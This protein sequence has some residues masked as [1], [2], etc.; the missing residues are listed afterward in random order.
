MPAGYS[1]AFVFLISKK[2]KIKKKKK[3]RKHFSRHALGLEMNLMGHKRLNRNLP[4]RFFPYEIK[5]LKVKASKVEIEGQGLL[6]Q[7]KISKAMN[8]LVE[9]HK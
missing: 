4:F 9:V 7:W 6:D 3:K 8:L 2:K 1:G 5:V